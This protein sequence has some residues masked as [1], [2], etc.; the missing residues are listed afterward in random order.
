MELKNKKINYDLK[1][2]EIIEEV[3]KNGIKKRLLIHSCCGP[4]SSAVLEYLNNFFDIDIYFYNPNITINYEY[5]HRIVEQKEM[6]DKLEYDMQVIEGEYNP[7]KDFFEKV[8]GLEN[9]KEG[10]ERCY[11]C[12]DLR[13]GA[14][15]KKAKAEGYDFFTTVLSISPMKNVNYI[16][17]IG[18][19]YSKEYEIPFLYA[20]FKKKNR[21]LRSIQ[22][23]KEL[24]MY[25][26]EYC[27]C[28]FSKIERENYEKEKLKNKLEIKE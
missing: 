25:R 28:I 13:I 22:I 18:E 7:E 21:Y 16:N 3:K 19:K 6:L 5:Q 12:Y 24:D 8:K 10:G 26:Q 9:A 1:M 20:D 17:E 2:E 15:A 14:T 11:V 23:S 4:C 27:G